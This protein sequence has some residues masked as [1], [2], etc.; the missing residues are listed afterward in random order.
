M[1]E[2]IKQLEEECRNLRN[3]V[4]WLASSLAEI[5]GVLARRADADGESE[6]GIEYIDKE[7][8]SKI[9]ELL[10]HD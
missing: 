8:N 2:K 5:A 3:A 10:K 6:S 9:K 1:E 4:R 7:A